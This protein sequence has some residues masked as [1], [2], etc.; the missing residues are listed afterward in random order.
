MKRLSCLLVVAAACGGSPKPT[1]TTTPLP[2]DNKAAAPVATAP[3][4]APAP[5][6]PP[7]PPQPLDVK[8]PGLSTTVKLVSGGKGKK[9]A[10]RYAPKEGAKQT[11]ELAMDFTGAQ[12]AEEQTV[13][14]MVLTA[15]AEA[16]SVA[17]DGAVEYALTVTGAD[18][19]ELSTKPDAPKVDIGKFKAAMA[20][21]PGLTIGG[22]LGANG[23]AGDLT[24]HMDNPP[25]HADQVLDL[26][27]VTLPRVPVLPAEAVGV[28][29][30]WQAT[31]TTKV[32]DRLDVTQVTDYEVTAHKGAA[33]T[34]KGTTKITGK[35]QQV[36]TSKVSD[37]S[38]SG[39]TEA[40]FENGS[41]FP[42]FKSSVETQFKATLDKDKTVTYKVRIGGGMGPSGAAA[43]PAASPAPPA[44]PKK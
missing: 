16:K 7:A 15:S 41:L 34:I 2:D 5:T 30:K 20:V 17:K 6:A 4:P 28:G 14:T 37:I 40:T 8:V 18:A 38:G 11:L 36:E 24:M 19:R 12:D 10:L 43:A 35:D 26:V 32:A 27:R 25:P 9:E 22:T 33:W 39:T 23:A 31:T 13:P 1:P 3:T 29:A 42:T 21:L 44:P